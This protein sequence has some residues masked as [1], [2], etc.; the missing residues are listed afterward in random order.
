[1][2]VD[3]DPLVDGDNALDPNL[4]GTVFICGLEE[5]TSGLLPEGQ[6]DLVSLH[7]FDGEVTEA[8]PH[9]GPSP[10][11]D[12]LG[13]RDGGLMGLGKALARGRL[14]DAR[15][16]ALGLLAPQPL[17][18]ASRAFI[19][20]GGR[21]FTCCF[22]DFQYALPVKMV[23]DESTVIPGEPRRVRHGSV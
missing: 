19:D 1:M 11:P 17:H 23:I 2:S 18:A 6:H 10:C 20:A 12:D 5:A 13:L 22:S 15:R 4:P 9:A 16:I 14:E 3:T 8:L 7:R 21:G